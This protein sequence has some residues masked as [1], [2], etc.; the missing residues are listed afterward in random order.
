MNCEKCGK[1]IPKNLNYCPSCSLAENS[2]YQQ[3]LKEQNKKDNNGEIKP[4]QAVASTVVVTCQ[5]GQKLEA[6]SK[7]CPQC[8]APINVST[9]SND[10]KKGVRIHLAIFFISIGVGLIIENIIPFI[11]ALMTMINA[12]IEFPESKVIKLIFWLYIIINVLFTLYIILI[13]AMCVGGG[14]AIIATCTSCA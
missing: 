9:N 4:E 7:V 2:N 3:Y 11:A 10:N 13:V 14:G 6:N 5:C 1:Q 8:N 12:L